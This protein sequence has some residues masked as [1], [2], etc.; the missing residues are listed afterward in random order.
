MKPFTASKKTCFLIRGLFFRWWR[1]DID[2]LTYEDMSKASDFPQNL[3]YQILS[4]LIVPGM[5]VVRKLGSNSY[6]RIWVTHQGK[7]TR[8]AKALLDEGLP[9]LWLKRGLF[10]RFVASDLQDWAKTHGEYKIA[11]GRVV[12]KDGAVIFQA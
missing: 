7:L 10:H 6:T 9:V 12:Y 3:G 4:T 5:R 11:G 2:T 8:H 1:W